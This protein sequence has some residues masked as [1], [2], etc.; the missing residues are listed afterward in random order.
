M[1]DLTQSQPTIL[2]L[3]EVHPL[4][5]AGSCPPLPKGIAR[6]AASAPRA[7][8]K[9]SIEYFELPARSILNR[10]TSERVPFRW[11]INPYRGCEFGCKYCYARYTHEYMELDGAEFERK[12]YAKQHA[13]ELLAR[14]LQREKVY[15]EHIAIGTATDPYQPAE[16]EFGVTRAI[17][18]TLA[19]KCG[20]SLSITT[21]S[22]QVVRDLDVLRRIHDRSSLH[23]NVTITTL[24]ARLARAL[25]PRAPTP[26]LRLEAVR[27]LRAAGLTV[28][29]FIMPVLPGITDRVEDL[30]ALVRAAAEHGAEYV[31]AGVLFL[32]PSAQKQFFPF[33]E[34]EF[35][36]LVKQYRKLYARSAYAPNEYKQRISQLMAA[37]RAKYGLSASPKE[38]VAEGLVAS[39]PQLS[40]FAVRPAQS[41]ASPQ[42]TQSPQT[43]FTPQP[44]AIVNRQFCSCRP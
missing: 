11:T 35:P 19:E 41:E 8:A 14:E 40:L 4:P 23:I 6:L 7:E 38:Y 20:L 42:R 34:G 16:R 10:C 33:L 36:R 43:N 24:N 22:N 39:S 29:V 5:S 37:L 44:P 21:K 26:A 30:E 13:R 27:I 12:I 1:H 28:G 9:R 32:M 18:E 17:L 3:A 25:E 2:P 15:G 31:A